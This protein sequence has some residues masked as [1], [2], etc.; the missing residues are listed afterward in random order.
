VLQFPPLPERLRGRRAA[1]V[2][3]CHTGAADQAMSLLDPIASI[4]T[5]LASTL[6]SLSVADLSTLYGAPAPPMSAR[7]RSGL[8]THLP[9]AAVRE[10]VARPGQH[11]AP[12]SRFRGA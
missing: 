12:A 6:R 11:P 9:A 4:G 7:I 1:V 8:L 2:T 10:F 3:I 5:P